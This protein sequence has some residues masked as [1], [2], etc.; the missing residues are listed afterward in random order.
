[1]SRSSHDNAAKALLGA[2]AFAL[3][4]AAWALV[5]LVV[6]G[7]WLF[8]AKRAQKRAEAAV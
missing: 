2:V 7:I 6:A 8:A 3:R 1:M 5:A 4:A